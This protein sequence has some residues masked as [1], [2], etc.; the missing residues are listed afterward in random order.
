MLSTS[1]EVGKLV[2]SATTAVSVTDGVP[3]DLPKILSNLLNNA[4]PEHK[5]SI[6]SLNFKFDKSAPLLGTS[7]IPHPPFLLNPDL[8]SLQGSAKNKEVISSKTLAIAAI[9]YIQFPLIAYR[10]QVIEKLNIQDELIG[11][12]DSKVPYDPLVE[13][14]G[15][16]HIVTRI[17]QD[18][19]IDNDKTEEE[20]NLAQN[21]RITLEALSD[22]LRKVAGDYSKISDLIELALS[23]DET[24]HKRQSI[25]KSIVLSDIYH[26]RGDIDPHAFNIELQF[27]TRKLIREV[28]GIYEVKQADSKINF[29]NTIKTAR[30]S[31]DIK[32]ALYNLA[33]LESVGLS[34]ISSIKPSNF[35]S[36]IESLASGN[37]LVDFRRLDKEH[38][39][40]LMNS[41]EQIFE[42]IEILFNIDNNLSYV[43]K[44]FLA[45]SKLEQQG[46]IK[47]SFLLTQILANLSQF[48]VFLE[49]NEISISFVAYLSKLNN[50]LTETIRVLQK[51]IDDSSFSLDFILPILEQFTSSE[52]S[53]LVYSNERV[54]KLRN[55]Y[56][57]LQDNSYTPEDIITIL[58]AFVSAREQKPE[59]TKGED[60]YP[61]N[62]S[63]WILY[64]MDKG[65]THSL[66]GL[67]QGGD[68][69]EILSK[70][71]EFIPIM[72][73]CLPLYEI[74]AYLKDW[75]PWTSNLAWDQSST[76]KEV[77]YQLLMSQAMLIAFEAD[78]AKL[79]KFIIDFMR[80]SEEEGSIF[81]RIRFEDQFEGLDE[82]KALRIKEIRGR[83]FSL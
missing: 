41:I 46:K 7:G 12:E 14:G 82:D 40:S 25:A 59:D 70:I 10:V 20:L 45:E 33:Q 30:S 18:I 68:D 76:S 57:R 26:N 42:N 29:I 60:K 81:H 51:N 43:D 53:K 58:R 49:S 13:Y 71:N 69:Q 73:K 64:T 35:N 4:H 44:L 74:C 17:R 11:I 50:F 24:F 23:S 6:S 52:S 47:E 32:E 16:L 55:T 34:P 77:Q 83:F 3:T 9:K 15:F 8:F 79:K 66:G 78:S 56:F 27:F 28:G 19:A 5:S 80:A 72:E 61:T 2:K 38:A 65:H 75:L 54:L 39:Y 31:E 48:P 21:R 36:W 37:G 22:A 1:H 63:E 67:V 62:I